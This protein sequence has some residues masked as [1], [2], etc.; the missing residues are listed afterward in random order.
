[1]LLGF[2]G[3]TPDQCEQK[4]IA[5]IFLEIDVAVQKYHSYFLFVFSGDSTSR[6]AIY[7]FVPIRE[8]KPAN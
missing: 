3:S 1:M 5:F 7:M 6:F 4:Q 8:F 2:V